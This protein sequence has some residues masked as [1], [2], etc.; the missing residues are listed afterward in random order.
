[1]ALS[2]RSGRCAV[3][4]APLP[5]CGR[6]AAACRSRE[7]RRSGAALQRESQTDRDGQGG[8]THWPRLIQWLRQRFFN[9]LLTMD[10]GSFAS[11]EEVREDREAEHLDL[12]TT[13]RKNSIT[14]QLPFWR[15]GKEMQRR[16]GVPKLKRS[17]WLAGP[18]RG[19]DALWVPVVKDIQRFW[20][21]RICGQKLIVSL[22]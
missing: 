2:R 11:P 14:V 6:A 19:W 4:V 9:D 17:C 21:T 10:T 3:A 18:S 1:M 12:C 7:G 13:K 20:T 15:H 16:W 22:E 8:T 5:G